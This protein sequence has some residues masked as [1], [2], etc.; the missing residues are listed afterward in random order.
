MLSGQ[1]HNCSYRTICLRRA[2]NLD[3]MMN[4]LYSV[5]EIETLLNGF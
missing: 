4:L 1:G 5:L 3:L 2:S